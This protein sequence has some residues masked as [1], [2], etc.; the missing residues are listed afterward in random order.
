MFLIDPFGRVSRLIPEKLLHKL[1][2]VGA[3][4]IFLSMLLKRAQEYHIYYVKPLWFVET[5]IYFVLVTTFLVRTDPVDRSQ[6]IREVIIPLVGSIIPFA[7][8]CSPPAPWIIENRTYI[9]IAF[10]WMTASTAFTVWGMWTL[11]RSFSITVEARALVTIGPYRFIRHPIYLG[12][13]L[14]SCA[15]AYWRFSCR[16]LAILM[17]FVVIQIA[18]SRWEERKL[19]KNFPE[20]RNYASKAWWVLQARG[21]DHPK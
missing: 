10:W 18:R 4:L 13:I 2:R 17:I 19:E 5:L 6:G 14:S 21:S 15:V 8:L 11:R 12:E 16:N 9:L 1:I 7:L 20:Y 3:V